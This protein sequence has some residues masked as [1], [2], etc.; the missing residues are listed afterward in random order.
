MRATAD[1]LAVKQQCYV[2]SII[3]NRNMVPI[4]IS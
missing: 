1:D 2:L 3:R 4:S